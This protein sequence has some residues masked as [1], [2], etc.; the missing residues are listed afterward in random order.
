MSVKQLITY[1]TLWFYYMTNTKQLLQCSTQIIVNYLHKS[2][3]D[4]IS[5]AHNAPRV[6]SK[7]HHKDG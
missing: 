6:I 3:H 7:S 5:L 4:I 1:Q 2:Y